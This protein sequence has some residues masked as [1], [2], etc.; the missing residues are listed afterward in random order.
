MDVKMIDV[1]DMDIHRSVMKQIDDAK[2][3][4]QWWAGYLGKK[5]ELG[6][7]DTINAQGEIQRK[8]NA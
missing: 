3:V 7:T 5:Y 8:L 1:N 4:W 2:V 6:A